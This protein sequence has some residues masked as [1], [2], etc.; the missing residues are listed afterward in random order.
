MRDG[1]AALS[2]WIQIWR[3]SP[4]RWVVQAPSRAMSAADSSLRL[5][6]VLTHCLLAPKP[7]RLRD[8]PVHLDEPSLIAFRHSFADCDKLMYR[9][10]ADDDTG[11]RF[12]C[13]NI[14]DAH[15]PEIGLEFGE[16]VIPGSVLRRDVFDPVIGTF[17]R[18]RVRSVC[19][20]AKW[21]KVTL[22]ASRVLPVQRMS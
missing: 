19:L 3:G 20:A 16:L 21:V 9:G 13:F 11:F 8:H 4:S 17:M 7:F 2:A 18:P 12:N 5:L 22:I 6:P 1:G 15:D 14:E 10:E